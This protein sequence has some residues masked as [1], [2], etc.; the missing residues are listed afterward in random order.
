MN[1][2][3]LFH[4][5]DRERP[6][7][8]YSQ[9]KQQILQRISEGALKLGDPLPSETEICTELNI[10][11][12][13]VRQAMGDLVAEGYLSRMK[14][15][16]TFVSQPKIEG[17]FFQKLQSF[18]EEMQQ[19]GLVPSTKVLSLAQIEGNAPLCE[20]LQLPEGAPL[21]FLERLRFAN[22]EPIVW[23][24]TYLP[25]ERFPKLLR[26]DFECHS[27]YREL[28]QTYLTPVERVVREIEA[29]NASYHEAELLNIKPNAAICFV[30]TV[31]YDFSN[32]PVEYSRA[33]YRGDRNQFRVE[34]HR[35][36]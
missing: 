22:G 4:G 31:S 36:N 34:L 9:I 26:V 27:L 28:K 17:G 3:T 23:V 33:H 7:P 30:T 35:S 18:D 1:V 24:E 29:T 14:G 32:K 19:K 21:V 11:R 5:I 8:L 2:Q 6:V 16:G 15:K 10:S 13:T 12:P 20:K 25:Y